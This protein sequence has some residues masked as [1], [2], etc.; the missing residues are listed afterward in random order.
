MPIRDGDRWLC[1]RSPLRGGPCDEGPAPDGGCCH[2]YRCDP[3]RSLRG[4]RGR[5]L[6]AC[7]I[8]TAGI[9]MIAIHSNGRDKLISPGPLARQHAQLEVA[10]SAPQNCAACHA[11]ANEGLTGWMRSVAIGHGSAPSQSQLCMDCHGKDISQ[12]FS[13][14]AHNLPPATLAKVTA[15]RG[16]NERRGSVPQVINSVFTSHPS[17]PA[18]AACHHEHHGADHNLAAIDN[19]SCQACHR[20]RYQSFADDHPD[21]GVWP[22]ER[23]TRIIFDHV[24]HQAKH[25]V[26]K[27]QP[28]NCQSCHVDDATHSVELL[29][30]YDRACAAC[31]DEKL[32]TSVGKGVAMIALPTLDVAAMRKVGADVGSWPA[33]ATGDFDGRLPP[34]M[35]LLLAGDREAAAA[36]AK[37]GP[38]FE[39][40]DVEADNAEQLRSVAAIVR[41]MKK[42]LVDLSESGPSAV[43]E[44]LKVALGREVS[45]Q[46][47]QPLLAGL[48]PD[49][50]RAATKAWLPNADLGNRDWPTEQSALPPEPRTL[51]PSPTYALA[52]TWNGD[53]ATFTIRY[54]L[55]AHADPVLASW[56]N[57]IV[58]TPKFDERPLL[59]AVAKELMK[60]TAPGLCAS[61]HSVERSSDSTL[62]INWLPYDRTTAGRTFTKFSH[63]PHLRLPQLTDCIACHTLDPQANTTAS[64]A[65][66]NPH[67]FAS[68]FQPMSK[69]KCAECHIAAAAGDSCQSCHR[70][71]VDGVDEWRTP[72]NASATDGTAERKTLE[73]SELGNH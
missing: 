34:P 35:K 21:F 42:L 48:S 50:I 15:A 8:A 13:R 71:H 23:R 51:N 31:H 11:A 44:R 58:S 68:E 61:C 52:G 72:Q 20:E 59:A 24:A 17:D 1:N 66:E 69:Q 14:T 30:S 37:L 40:S 26:D 12:E 16:E 57:L 19:A 32:R 46:A 49:T 3:V 39:F 36:L 10:G 47:T 65:D 62:A 45:E 5:F 55:A 41:G 9:L 4:K 27:K 67:R 64:Y 33:A 54:R 2:V 53:D 56:L 63:G 22:Y 73:Q 70:Y 43:R 6:A 29:T 38:T 7:A 25:F 18:C 60:P 28:F